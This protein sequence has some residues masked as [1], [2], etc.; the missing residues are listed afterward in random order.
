MSLAKKDIRTQVGHPVHSALRVLASAA[1]YTIERYAERL[2][3]HHVVS[4]AKDAILLAD[5]FQ[6]AG[7]DRSFR[8]SA[9]DNGVHGSGLGGVDIHLGDLS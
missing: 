9:F 8:E 4:K 3:T 7:I 2:I 5:E 6:R 1:G